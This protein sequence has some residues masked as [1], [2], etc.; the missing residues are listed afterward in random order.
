M[1]TAVDLAWNEVALRFLKDKHPSTVL[2]ALRGVHSQWAQH[3][4]GWRARRRLGSGT[5]TMGGSFAHPISMNFAM[6]FCPARPELLHV[7]RSIMA[8]PNA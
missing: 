5:W 3:M 7:L 6:S 1:L 8:K 2:D 4:Y